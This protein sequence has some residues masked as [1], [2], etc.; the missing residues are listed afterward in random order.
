VPTVLFTQVLFSLTLEDFSIRP[1]LSP[2]HHN[3]STSLGRHRSDAIL[4]RFPSRARKMGTAAPPTEAQNKKKK[5]KK[6]QI[7]QRCL[8]QMFH[9][10]GRTEIHYL[11]STEQ[12]RPRLHRYCRSYIDSFGTTQ[13]TKQYGNGQRRCP[14]LPLLPIFLCHHNRRSKKNTPQPKVF[15]HHGGPFRFGSTK[16]TATSTR[17]R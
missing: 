11:A 5:E 12:E 1:L 14:K 15:G 2:N 6:N 3:G 16:T 9:P 7:Q 10:L 8:R 4:Q 13:K 17:G